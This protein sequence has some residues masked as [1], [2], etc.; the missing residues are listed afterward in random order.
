MRAWSENS[1]RS[2]ERKE[3]AKPKGGQL[4]GGAPAKNK[5]GTTKFPGGGLQKEG[6]GGKKR[7]NRY[8]NDE[9]S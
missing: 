4:G 6:R 2:G 1:V 8:S 9:T 7:Q 3:V 5:K